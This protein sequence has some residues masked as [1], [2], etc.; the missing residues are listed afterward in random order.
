MLR[1][2]VRPVG[3][4][5]VLVLA[6]AGAAASASVIACGGGGKTPDVPGSV[7]GAP[8]ASAEPPASPSPQAGSAEPASE[9]DRAADPAPPKKRKPFSIHSSCPKVVTVVFAEDPKAPGAGKRTIAP[10]SAIDGPR[11]DSGKQMVWLLD[12]NGAPLI[13]VTVTRGIKEVEIGRSCST[14]DAH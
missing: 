11:D 2:P 5:L 14:L 3:P 13:K 12:D 9:P 10:N 6:I 1:S 8:G 7:P 4:A